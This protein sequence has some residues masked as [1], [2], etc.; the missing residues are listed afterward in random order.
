MSFFCREQTLSSV[1]KS[2]STNQS[3][4]EDIT[5]KSFGRLEACESGGQEL[6]ILGIDRLEVQ[7]RGRKL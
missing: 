5:R 4:L 3:A 7:S 1:F 6:D 2:V